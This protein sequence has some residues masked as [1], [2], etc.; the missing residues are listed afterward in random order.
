M[1]RH[2]TRASTAANVAT[3]LLGWSL[4]TAAGGGGPVLQLSNGQQLSCDVCVGAD[5]ANSVVAAHLGLPPTN[6]AGYVAYR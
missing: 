1:A 2:L 3:G 6:Y 5:G 4:P